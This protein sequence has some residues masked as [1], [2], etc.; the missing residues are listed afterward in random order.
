MAWMVNHE[1]QDR[2]EIFSLLKKGTQ[3]MCLSCYDKHAAKNVYSEDTYNEMKCPY[4]VIM[5]LGIL[6]ALSV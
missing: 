1:E 4:L 2:T 6:A 5:A 3:F